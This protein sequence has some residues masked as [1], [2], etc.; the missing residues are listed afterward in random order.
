M[1]TTLVSWNNMVYGKLMAYLGA[2]LTGISVAVENS[3]A[4]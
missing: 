4:S 1:F 3:E 2:I